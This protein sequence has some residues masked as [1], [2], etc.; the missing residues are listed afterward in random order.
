MR[1]TAREIIR[2]GKGLTCF[3]LCIATLVSLAGAGFVPAVPQDTHQSA[4]V[5]VAAPLED[6]ATILDA[7]AIGPWQRTSAAAYGAILLNGGDGSDAWALLDGRT[8]PTEAAAAILLVLAA[9]SS[10]GSEPQYPASA[11]GSAM[12]SAAQIT[13][14]S[15]HYLWR[16]AKRESGFDPSAAA[17]TSSAL[18]LFQFVEDTWLLTVRRYGARH[19]LGAESRAISLDGSTPV[20]LDPELR[21]RVLALRA[22]PW[23]ASRMAAELARDNRRALVRALARP[24]TDDEVYLAHFLGAFG[25]VRLIRAAKIAPTVSAPTLLPAAAA[26]NRRVFWRSGRPLTAAQVVEDLTGRREGE[27]EGVGRADVKLRGQRPN[28]GPS[29]TGRETWRTSDVSS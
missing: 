1:T 13:G 3:C 14:V 29:R 10:A 22:D 18:G 20:L 5:V 12:S 23:I 21:Q 7:L 9:R 15:P 24:V 19:G 16:T 26:A 6:P 2:P 17:R 28:T 25:A 4:R 27:G 11:V 8:T